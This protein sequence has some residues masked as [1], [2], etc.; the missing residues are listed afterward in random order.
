MSNEIRQIDCRIVGREVSG[1][2]VKVSV[3][4]LGS[5]W[6]ELTTNELPYL[7]HS[8]GNTDYVKD[9]TTTAGFDYAFDLVFD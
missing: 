2:C 1:S 5:D 7:L 9:T 8:L 6:D 3:S 4:L